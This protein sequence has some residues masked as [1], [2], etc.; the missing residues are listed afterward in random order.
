M[1][2]SCGCTIVTQAKVM[3]NFMANYFSDEIV[4][5]ISEIVVVYY[6]SNIGTIVD[7]IT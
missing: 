3:A 7:E 2:F 1:V 6:I 4:D 5:T